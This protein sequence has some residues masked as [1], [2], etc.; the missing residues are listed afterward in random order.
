MGSFKQPKSSD[1][2]ATDRIRTVYHEIMDALESQN[3]LSLDLDDHELK[4]A[5]IRRLI[6][7]FTDGTPHQDWKSE[8]LRTLPLR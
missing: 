2:I 7:L 4:A 8:V 5:V 1:P 3:V 6:K